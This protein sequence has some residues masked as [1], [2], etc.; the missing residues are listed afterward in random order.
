MILAT[1]NT[2]GGITKQT[3]QSFSITNGFQGHADMAFLQTLQS[4]QRVY[5]RLRGY[6]VTGSVPIDFEGLEV[7]GGDAWPVVCKQTCISTNYAWSIPVQ[8]SNGQLIM[9]LRDAVVNGSPAYFY[10]KY[11]DWA[12]FKLQYSPTDF[13]IQ[14]AAEWDAIPYLAPTEV[15]FVPNSSSDFRDIAGFEFGTGYSGGAYAVAKHPWPWWGPLLETN[16]MIDESSTYCVSNDLI[17]TVFNSD[18][19]IQNAL[20]Q[21]DLDS[22]T[23]DAIPGGGGG[24]TW[25]GSFTSCT[26]MTTL[27]SVVDE[28][29]NIDVMNWVTELVD[30]ATGSNGTYLWD[31][32]LMVMVDPIDPTATGP[33]TPV[34]QIQIDGVKDPRLVKVP[35]TVVQPGLYEAKVI[36]KNGQILRHFEEFTA[37]VVFNSR[38]ASFVDV[39]IYPVPVTGKRFAVD[40]ELLYPMMMGLTILDNVGN[41]MYAANYQYAQPGRHKEVVEMNPLWNNGLYHAVIQYPDGSSET[42]H[43]NV[44]H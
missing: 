13:H 28:N 29:G 1:P 24:V 30:C 6:T 3:I 4:D 38:F 25:G 32:V 15:L 44:Q 27:E 21:Y 10:V 40:F 37:P 42:V 35:R 23:C 20:M 11:D 16:V 43:F 7:G 18:G 39:N 2:S 17:R 26:S 31:D 14:C 36:L 8:T 12:Q 19:A 9:D 33:G 41:T 5:Y 34:L 22:V